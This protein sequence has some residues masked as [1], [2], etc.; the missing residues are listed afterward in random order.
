VHCETPAD[1]A[2]PAAQAVQ[3]TPSLKKPALH[4]SGEHE[5]LPVDVY[6]T[7]VETGHVVHIAAPAVAE[8]VPAAQGVQV[9]DPTS[10]ENLPASQ[11]THCEP[12][13]VSLN[14]PLAQAVQ[15]D[16]AAEENL[17]AGQPAHAAP[18]AAEN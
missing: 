2:L 5:L 12:L 8:M 16:D 10:L 15:V 11:V 9:V 13:D 4:V 18:G 3:T 7:A 1:E 6:A 14:V 17:P